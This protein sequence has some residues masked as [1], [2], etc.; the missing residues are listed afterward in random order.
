[1]NC[2]KDLEEKQTG[3]T[4]AATV[5][6]IEDPAPWLKDLTIIR[7][8]GPTLGWILLLPASRRLTLL[9]K[10]LINN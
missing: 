7:P 10:N 8:P 2:Q 3:V 9:M 1:M 4:I 5:V 6:A